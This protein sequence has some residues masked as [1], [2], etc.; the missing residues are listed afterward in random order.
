[1][2]KGCTADANDSGSDFSNFAAAGSAVVSHTIA[3][4]GKC[5]NS[6]WKGG[7]YGIDT[8]TSMAAPHAAGVVALCIATGLC[9]NSTPAKI[10]TK[11]R[12]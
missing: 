12:G 1:M 11:L 8:G 7:T 6:T 9:A 10:I 2:P 5:I 3:A 4:P